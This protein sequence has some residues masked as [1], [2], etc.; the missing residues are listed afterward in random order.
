[1]WQSSIAGVIASSPPDITPQSAGA[2]VGLTLA[3]AD[4]AELDL[5]TRVNANPEESGGECFHGRQ[6]AT[7]RS[8]A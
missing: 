6:P 3:P 8:V 1:V 4:G 5:G 2:A 7:A